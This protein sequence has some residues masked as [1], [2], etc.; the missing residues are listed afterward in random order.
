[1]ANKHIKRYSTPLARKR[2]I[3]TTM[4]QETKHLSEWLKQKI[5]TVPDAD[6]DERK[7]GHSHV[8]GGNV[9]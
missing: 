4:S 6:E 1:M 2:Q 7:P 5:M 8:A 9:K 3:E